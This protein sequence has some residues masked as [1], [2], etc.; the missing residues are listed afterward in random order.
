MDMI[1]WQE[2][3]MRVVA[4]ALPEFQDG[5]P[6]VRDV[7]LAEWLGYK[8]PVDIRGLIR[9][10]RKEI[11][12]FGIICTVQ[13][14][15]DGAGRPAEEF[16]LTE[17][18]SIAVSQLSEG[19]RA[20]Q[21]RVALRKM[22]K[23]YRDGKLQPLDHQTAVFMQVAADRIIAPILAEQRAFHEQVLNR[24]DATDRRVA[25]IHGQMLNIQG[26]VEDLASKQR[27]LPRSGDRALLVEVVRKYFSSR[28]PC[29]GEFLIL[30]SAG[31]PNEL[32]QVDHF[33]GKHNARLKDI[34]AV[35]SSCNSRL[36]KEP[37]F[38]ADH[39]PEFRTFQNRLTNQGEQGLLF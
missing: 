19:P 17:D 37:G 8:N 14:I 12:A 30:D 23:A 11:E 13:K 27:K 20:S 36:D 35:C 33:N 15:H 31:R 29:C 24:M 18:Q 39:M 25:T 6:R 3:D 10:N 22:Y 16:W 34:W 9:R 5:Q 38:K 2:H 21:V 7:D 4:Q 32:F 26:T 28:C 1:H